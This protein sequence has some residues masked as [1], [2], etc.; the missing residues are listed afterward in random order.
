MVLQRPETLATAVERYIGEA[1]LRGEFAP[2]QPLPE[3]QLADRVGTSR[4]TV[5]E[6]LRMLSEQGLVD[7]YP[8]RGV[9]VAKLTAR[10]AHDIF[11][12]R[13]E[14]ESYAVRLAVSQGG[15][16]PDQRARQEEA[17]EALARTIA[18]GDPFAVAE[19]DMRFHETLTLGSNHELLLETLATLRL[20][21]RQAIVATKLMSSDLEPEGVTHRRL[22][23]A[24]R[25]GDADRAAA[26]V[27][28]HI[29]TAGQ[30]LLDKL[31]AAE[32]DGPGEAGGRATSTGTG[33][34]ART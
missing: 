3:I 30:L 20:R 2:G 22:I 10:R 31:R 19:A 17:L 12:L 9:F 18:D 11:T 32:P 29:L 33:G 5:R 24:V 8:H 28:D 1:I 13:A 4:G 15:Y 21:M 6:A 34:P 27:R 16:S 23:Q 26:A 14:L 25:S 7:I